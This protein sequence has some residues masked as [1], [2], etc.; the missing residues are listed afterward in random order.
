[1]ENFLKL[2][3]LFKNLNYNEMPEI[4]LYDMTF[5]LVEIS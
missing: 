4:S 1:M 3:L 2:I 5:N